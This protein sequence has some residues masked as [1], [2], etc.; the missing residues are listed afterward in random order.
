MSKVLIALMFLVGAMAIAEIDFPGIVIP[1]EAVSQTRRAHKYVNH[2]LEL[3]EKL[4]TSKY[5]LFLGCQN[6]AEIL[7]DLKQYI[8]NG[9]SNYIAGSNNLVLGNG[10][11]V[12]GSNNKLAGTDN[13]VLTEKDVTSKE[14]ESNVLYIG[15]WRIKMDKIPQI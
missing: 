3:Y 12:L 4:K 15:K 5:T 10:N 11:V 2:Q 8:L 6:Y 13:W 14:V 7:L 1:P 9:V